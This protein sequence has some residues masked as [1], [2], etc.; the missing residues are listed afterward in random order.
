MWECHY[1][2][3]MFQLTIVGFVVQKGIPVF[4]GFFF[5]NLPALLRQIQESLLSKELEDVGASV[6]L[7]QQIQFLALEEHFKGN[8][9]ARVNAVHQKTVG[10]QNLETSF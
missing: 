10:S 5:Y 6:V 2:S 4:W 8:S 3:Q 9:V 7:P 1:S